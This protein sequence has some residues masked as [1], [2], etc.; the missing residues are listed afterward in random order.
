MKWGQA[1]RHMGSRNNEQREVQRKGGGS[2]PVQ[3]TVAVGWRGLLCGPGPAPVG[4]CEPGSE[5]AIYSKGD[6][7]HGGIWTGRDMVWWDVCLLHS[8]D[9]QILVSL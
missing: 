7:S 4:L 5:S 3:E 8:S 2:E 6:G 1:H 9:I